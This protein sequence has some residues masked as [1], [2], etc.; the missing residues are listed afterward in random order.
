MTFEREENELDQ[1]ASP[2]APTNMDESRG[3]ADDSLFYF[4]A[5]SARSMSTQESY[6]GLESIVVGTS[7][8]MEDNEDNC[9]PELGDLAVMDEEDRQEMVQQFFM[10]LG[11][12]ESD[13]TC[14]DVLSP[15]RALDS[16]DV[17]SFGSEESSWEQERVHPTLCFKYKPINTYFERKSTH[18]KT[19]SNHGMTMK[20]HT[21]VAS[22]EL[23]RATKR[24][25]LQLAVTKQSLSSMIS[26]QTALESISQTWK[27]LKRVTIH[28]GNRLYKMQCIGRAIQQVALLRRCFYPRRDVIK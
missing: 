9:N 4:T 10:L 22:V 26:Q 16:F 25:C 21:V 14:T 5:E 7:E 12:P 15:A 24:Q 20:L 3:S 18:E 8:D 17:Q 2:L 13:S 19:T 1:W 6:W 27:R 23:R 28:I 11:T